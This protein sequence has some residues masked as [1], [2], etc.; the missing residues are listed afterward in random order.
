M[1]NITASERTVQLRL[2]N[3]MKD[4]Q[5]EYLQIKVSKSRLT[6]QKVLKSQLRAQSD[7]NSLL[8]HKSL[9]RNR[10]KLNGLGQLATLGSTLDKS[11]EM[12]NRIT[13]LGQ[14]SA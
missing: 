6:K 4:L 7:T 12:T 8:G 13:Q 10:S 5:A 1:S 14:A 9:A 3:L 2:K 11:I